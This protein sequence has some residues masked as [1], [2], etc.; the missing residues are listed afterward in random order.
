MSLK[1][2]DLCKFSFLGILNLVIVS[3]STICTISLKMCL[4]KIKVHV[5]PLSI[6]WLLL[7]SRIEDFKREKETSLSHLS[8]WLCII[9]LTLND[10]VDLVDSLHRDQ[11]IYMHLEIPFHS[12]ALGKLHLLSGC[13]PYTLWHNSFS[14]FPLFLCILDRWIDNHYIK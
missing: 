14:S 5:I 8:S 2:Q 13:F 3:R 12:K 10:F 4:Q 6:V 11:C 9:H 7:K 1:L